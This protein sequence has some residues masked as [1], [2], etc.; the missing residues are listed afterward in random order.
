MI[1]YEFGRFTTCMLSR[2]IRI[3][4]VRP[5]QPPVN[6]YTS[7]DCCNEQIIFPL[8]SFIDIPNWL[9]TSYVP[10]AEENPNCTQKYQDYFR[11]TQKV[12]QSYGYD[13]KFQRK[14]MYL[15]SNISSTEGWDR[16]FMNGGKNAI[17]HPT[18]FRPNE[19]DK[20]NSLSTTIRSIAK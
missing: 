19:N 20:G 11:L 6:S 9:S 14:R 2:C 1:F 16:P 15:T 3:W 5:F 10:V 17:G 13:D 12:F 18:C 7:R 8:L 4:S